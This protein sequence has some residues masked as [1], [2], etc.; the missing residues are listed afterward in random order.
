MFPVE[1]DISHEKD[2]VLI[3]KPRKLKQLLSIQAIE[4]RYHHKLAV[5]TSIFSHAVARHQDQVICST[6]PQLKQLVQHLQRD[7]ELQTVI[8]A[9]E[10]IFPESPNCDYVVASIVNH[11]KGK[12]P[13]RLFGKVV[14]RGNVVM[15][16]ASGR[17]AQDHYHTAFI[18]PIID[19]DNQV[20]LHVIDPFT[21]KTTPPNIRKWLARIK[22]DDIA[23]FYQSR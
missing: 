10:K 16:L 13:G 2:S 6:L 14:A 20:S 1:C 22:S 5:A 3:A 23:F 15:L 11:F 17:Q 19:E 7:K 12:Y 8:H 4:E 21:A 18:A 9:E